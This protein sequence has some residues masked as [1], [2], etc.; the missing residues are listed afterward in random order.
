M[1]NQT[2]WV[3]CEF[4]VRSSDDLNL[5]KKLYRNVCGSIDI[6]GIREVGITHNVFY[7]VHDNDITDVPLKLICK[8][9]GPQTLCAIAP[10]INKNAL[11]DHLS[12][13]DEQFINQWTSYVDKQFG[14]SLYDASLTK[15]TVPLRNINEALIVAVRS[16]YITHVIPCVDMLIAINGNSPT[17]QYIIISLDSQDRNMQFAFDKDDGFYDVNDTLYE[18]DTF[19]DVNEKYLNEKFVEWK[20]NNFENDFVDYFQEYNKYLLKDTN[21]DEITELLNN[22]Y[23]QPDT[24]FLSKIFNKFF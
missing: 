20:E 17:S 19:V 15:P 6:G 7:W 3:N 10:K 21:R 14:F 8:F 9:T 23:R 5:L 22:T 1:N 2:Y 12:I 13:S 18:D 11:D 16:S 4:T 24:S